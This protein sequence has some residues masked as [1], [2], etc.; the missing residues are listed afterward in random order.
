MWHKCKT[1]LKCEQCLKWG[2]ET[3]DSFCSLFWT[4]A[5]YIKLDQLL[6]QFKMK[7]VN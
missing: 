1:E 4:I 6:H 7:I 5:Y 3:D 2:K